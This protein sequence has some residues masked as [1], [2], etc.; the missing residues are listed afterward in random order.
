M[1]VSC[2]CPATGRRAGLTLWCEPRDEFVSK[3]SM[4][5]VY[6]SQHLSFTTAGKADE[7]KA[8]VRTRFGKSDRLGS[9]GGL[10][11]RGSRWNCEPTSQPKGRGW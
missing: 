4:E 5:G 1:A 7:G 2:V 8:K 10:G 9:Q 11:K 3:L 6:V